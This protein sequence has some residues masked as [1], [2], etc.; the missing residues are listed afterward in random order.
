[1]SRTALLF[2]IV[3]L[4]SAGLQ[5]A[6]IPRDKDPGVDGPVRVFTCDPTGN[7][8]EI[9]FESASIPVEDWLKEREARQIPMD[10]T[11]RR[12][13]LR[14]DQQTSVFYEAKVHLKNSRTEQ[15]R[16][17]AFFVGV[18]SAEGK[19]LTETSVHAVTVP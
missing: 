1:M 12:P 2:P 7:L 6:Q 17:V 14:M 18:D 11:L 13:E 3:I 5:P 9:E 10:M 4:T 8:D 19:R 16:K 15:D